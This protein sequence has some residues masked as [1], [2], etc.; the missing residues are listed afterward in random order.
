MKEEQ[1]N[2][3]LNE[4]NY[5]KRNIIKMNKNKK[6]LMCSSDVDNN[7]ILYINSDRSNI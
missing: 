5:F 3:H 7:M 1:Q 4:F 6:T 2:R